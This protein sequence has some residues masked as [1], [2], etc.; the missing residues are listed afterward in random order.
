MKRFLLPVLLTLSTATYADEASHKVLT[1]KLLETTNAQSSLTEAYTQIEQVFITSMKELRLPKDMQPKVESHIEKMQKVLKE[2]LDWQ[3]LKQPLTELYMK[4]YTESEMKE[5][6][7]F[8]KTE[9][10]QKL[11]QKA[12]E[13][14]KESMDISGKVLQNTLPKLQAIQ[15]ELQKAVSEEIAKKAKEAEAA[16]EETKNKVKE[17]TD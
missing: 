14:M 4:T 11:L 13:L 16:I 10:G 7:A 8:Y 12:P 6:L 17:S 2:E 15:M 1:E 9:A 3:K 5:I